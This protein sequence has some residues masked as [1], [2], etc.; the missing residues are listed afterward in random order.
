M[1]IQEELEPYFQFY[2]NAKS[3]Y[4]NGVAKNAELVKSL[5]CVVG[6]ARILRYELKSGSDSA[7][8]STSNAKSCFTD[9]SSIDWFEKNIE[10]GNPDRLLVEVKKITSSSS[11]V[12]PNFDHVPEL[13]QTILLVK[14][15]L[16]LVRKFMRF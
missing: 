13:V 7:S 5:S 10:F 12:I 2:C 14:F 9:S 8:I 6:L 3:K 1:A 4:K 15:V 11:K 16:V